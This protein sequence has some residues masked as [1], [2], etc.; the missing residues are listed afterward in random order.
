MKTILP[1]I[2]LIIFTAIACNH[3]TEKQIVYTAPSSNN[4]ELWADTIIYDV[5]ISNP[6]STDDW[7][8]Q[9]LKHLDHKKIVDDLFESIYSGQK[10]AYN[11]Y[12]N[13]E[14]SIEDIKEFEEDYPR[15]N[16]GK[17]QFS[18]SWLY[19]K[20]LGKHIKQVHSILVAYTLYDSS[21][22]IRGYKAGFFIKND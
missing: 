7:Q 10:K 2:L 4:L 16:I 13:S 5:L 18:E 9:K 11:Y 19:D 15:S 14:Y 17:L 12:T 3:N 1:T 20:T 6:D 8:E 21:N 22:N